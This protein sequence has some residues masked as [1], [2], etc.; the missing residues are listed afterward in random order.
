[1]SFKEELGW[2]AQRNVC[3]LEVCIRKST[4]T[5]VFTLREELCSVYRK[6]SERYESFASDSCSVSWYIS[7]TLG[8]MPRCSAWNAV[9]ALSFDR[10][11]TYTS[12]WRRLNPKESRANTFG[13]TAGRLQELPDL[14]N[15]T[16]SAFGAPLSISGVYSSLHPRP[17]DPF[18]SRLPCS[19]WLPEAVHMLSGVVWTS[20]LHM[21]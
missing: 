16:G 18:K 15:H 6:L 2:G 17:L 12:H 13:M 20:S 1:M 9:N 4:E 3:H 10:S 11:Q 8:A 5:D 19:C 14:Q 21:V 7:V